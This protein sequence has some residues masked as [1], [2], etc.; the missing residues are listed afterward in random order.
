MQMTSS[1]RKFLVIVRAGDKSLHRK[2]VE[3]GDRNWDLVVSWY[4]E[5]AYT[6]VADERVLAAKGWKWDVLADQFTAHPELIDSYEL[7]FLPD[8]DIETNAGQISRMFEIASA[9][10]LAVSQPALTQDS[11]FSHTHTLACRSFE[12]RYTDFVEVMAPCLAP[13]I[14]RLLMP[15]L[16]MSPSGYGL[17]LIWTRLEADNHERAAIIDAT[18]M[19]HTRPVGRFLKG[20]MRVAGRSVR[21]EGKA[22]AA[23]YGADWR[24]GQ[25][26]C[27]SGVAT[28]GGR[29]ARWAT[30]WHMLFDVVGS[31]GNWV[32]EGAARRVLK[33]F[34]Q[35]YRPAWSTQLHDSK[36][37]SSEP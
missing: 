6:P 13:H 11:Y 21:D 9:R 37:N 28:L 16:P 34:L 23:R 14:L 30:A 32:Q 3:G 10:R 27:Y 19:R 17:D 35:V 1:G 2:W 8:D 18:P 36:V 24:Q 33:M 5:E 15:V 22:L 4:G 7:I 25:F 12:L 20:R 31:Y 29:R 26:H